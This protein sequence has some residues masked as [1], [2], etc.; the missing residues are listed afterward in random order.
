MSVHHHLKLQLIRLKALQGW[1]I[2][3]EGVSFLFLSTGAGEYVWGSFGRS[4]SRPLTG[5][6]VLVV[7]GVSGGKIRPGL[8]A[9]LAFYAFSACVE[10]LFPVLTVEEI[11]LVRPL[12]AELKTPRLHSAASSAAAS[13]QALIGRVGAGF[14]LEH[15]SQ[16]LHVAGAI[17]CEEFKKLRPPVSFGRSDARVTRLFEQLSVEEIL[18]LSAEEMAHRFGCSQRQLNRLFN[19]HFGLSA[20]MLRMEMRLLRAIPLL[21]NS[22]LKIAQVAGQCGF[23]HLSLFHACFRRRFGLSPGQWRRTVIMHETPVRALAVGRPSCRLRDFGLCPLD[24]TFREA[25]AAKGPGLSPAAPISRAG[26]REP[27][28]GQTPAGQGAGQ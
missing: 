19:E 6:D 15:R 4:A 7:Q 25:A 22:D 17:L 26:D 14:D 1:N 20:G 8:G 21:Q 10:H 27:L 18:H 28:L 13:W 3:R 12:L 11:A 16:L 24:E 23:N 9:G 5:G 2:P